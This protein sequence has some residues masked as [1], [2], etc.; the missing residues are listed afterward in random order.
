M[1]FRARPPHG[2][3]S[4]ATLLALAGL[5]L[6]AAACGP[7]PSAPVVAA[8]PTASSSASAPV[9]SASAATSSAPSASANAP[10]HAG[11]L[12]AVTSI[13][14]VF[15]SDARGCVVLSSHKLACWGP[16]PRGL[17][18]LPT[19]FD[20]VN[21]VRSV[22]F[23]YQGM[24][25]V[26]QSGSVD[27]LRNPSNEKPASTFAVKS[28]GDV[29]KLETGETMIC[30]L[31]RTGKV[32]CWGIWGD[33][34]PKPLGISE[35]AVDLAVGDHHACIADDAGHVVCWGSGGNGELGLGTKGTTPDFGEIVRV[36][37]IADVIAVSAGAVQSCALRKEGQV[38]CWGLDQLL[39]R[40]PRLDDDKLVA[41]T[42]RPVPIPGALAI[43]S[44]AG[45]TC[46]L[47]P[48]GSA[49]CWGYN[50]QG[51]LGDGT[52]ETRDSPIRVAGLEHI[53]RIAPGATSC[54]LTSDGKLACWGNLIHP[55]P[56]AVKN[57]DK[58]TSLS[59]G[60]NHTCAVRGD[61]EVVCW[62]ERDE[63]LNQQV[64]YRD[65]LEPKPMGLSKASFVV[66]GAPSSRIH[67]G[68]AI[69]DGGKVTCFSEDGKTTPGVDD[70]TS[71]AIGQGHGCALRRNGN[72]ACWGQNERLQ[73]ATPGAPHRTTAADIPG[74]RDVIAIAA[75][76]DTTCALHKSGSV[77]CWGGGAEGELG[78]G[79]TPKGGAPGKVSGL[80]DAVQISL[81]FRHACARRRNGRVSCWGDNLFGRVTNSTQDLVIATPKDTPIADAIDVSVGT[82]AACV[83]RTSGRVSCWGDLNDTTRG[84]ATSTDARG[85]A[86]V[87]G[88][89]DA[90]HVTLGD[91]HACASTKRGTTMCWGDDGRG[92][93]GDGSG[94]GV[95]AWIAVPA[96]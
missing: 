82:Q 81:G 47:H 54:A 45:V 17:F 14:D 16:T 41:G 83:V 77:T 72:V 31:H 78:R 62:G 28:L 94:P 5:S 3:V 95:P 75:G 90:T 60:S 71:V 63:V 59:A 7:S 49:S 46:A 38:L 33:P 32:D 58:A 91:N 69:T 44:D 51:A 39:G 9:A 56:V 66:A 85:I 27:L 87:L 57:L 61:A 1:A 37:D 19:V 42:V 80:D 20:G 18:S 24:Y 53:A 76:G 52:R 43:R 34:E 21:D 48:G 64:F 96:P 22:A 2:V 30:A 84:G 29:V 10:V 67:D 70:A 68:C 12:P 93:I 74:V 13:V 26:H 92:Q 86:D 40:G 8:Q 65:A 23:T 55:T 4:F 73:L 89:V 6:S 88:L 79:D 25:V 15:V 50:D 35:K 11:E 36:G